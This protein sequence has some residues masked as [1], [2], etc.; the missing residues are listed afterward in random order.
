MSS[1]FNMA[2]EWV[3]TRAAATVL[4]MTT[5]ETLTVMQRAAAD[6]E[7][8]SYPQW[9]QNAARKQAAA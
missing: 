3:R 5:D 8:K 4:K 7:F 1:P 2:Q 9:L 6:V